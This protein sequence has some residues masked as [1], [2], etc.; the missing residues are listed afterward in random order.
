M[1]G[2][3]QV[4]E[5]SVTAGHVVCMTLCRRMRLLL[6]WREIDLAGN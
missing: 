2:R 3:G 6:R 4:T 1:Q 5:V